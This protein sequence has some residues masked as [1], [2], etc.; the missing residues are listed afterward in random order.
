MA[1]S[2]PGKD[3]AAQIVLVLLCLLAFGPVMLA[4]LLKIVTLETRNGLRQI[5]RTVQARAHPGNGFGGD[6]HAPDDPG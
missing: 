1:S 3:R 2:R 6:A 5:Q 4:A